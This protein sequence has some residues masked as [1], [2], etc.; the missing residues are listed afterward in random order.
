MLV[1]SE[2]REQYR[3]SVEKCIDREPFYVSR[4]SHSCNYI[5]A[6]NHSPYFSYLSSFTSICNPLSYDRL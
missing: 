5:P 6:L 4:S 1:E 3:L 2:R